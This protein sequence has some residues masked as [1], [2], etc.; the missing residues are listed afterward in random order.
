MTIWS[1]EGSEVAGAMV[2]SQEGDLFARGETV[3]RQNNQFLIVKSWQGDKAHGILLTREEW[4]IRR[5]VDE[6]TAFVSA[7]PPS[8]GLALWVF[9]S[10]FGDAA[11]RLAAEQDLGPA[12]ISH[13]PWPHETEHHAVW[14]DEYRAAT[15]RDTWAAQANRFK[16]APAKEITR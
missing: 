5:Q 13:A 8:K 3:L 9:G 7:P 16:H 2:G 12:L 15:H 1:I 6:A 14:V 4:E 11:I 10:A